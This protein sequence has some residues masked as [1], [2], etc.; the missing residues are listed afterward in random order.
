MGLDISSAHFVD[1]LSSEDW[2]LE[3]VPKPVHAVLMLYPIKEATEAH[4]EAEQARIDASGQV[5][6][7][8]VYYMK[9]TVGN[10]CGTIAILHSIGNALDSVR[11]VPASYLD[12]FY[13]QT[14][15]LGPDEIAEYLCRDD[16]LEECHEDAAAEGQ[17]EQV[18]IDEDVTTHFICF[19]HDLLFL[20][21]TV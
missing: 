5:I 1:V 20:N 18:D 16:A 4:L 9:Q 3:M 13:R 17:S 15:S 19:R 2:A 11:I 21:H 14:R 6:S 12:N 10:A 8:A 7:P